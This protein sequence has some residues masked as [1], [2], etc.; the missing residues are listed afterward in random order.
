MIAANYINRSVIAVFA[1]TLTV[2]LLIAVGER[3][4][5]FL[6]KAALGQAGTRA[7]SW[8]ER[9]GCDYNRREP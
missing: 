6:E 2:I 3:F 7:P 4:T 9:D 5:H 1:T 8:S